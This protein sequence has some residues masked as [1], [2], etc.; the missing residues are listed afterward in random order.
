MRPYDQAEEA[1]GVHEKTC[2]RCE[3]SELTENGA[4]RRCHRYPQ[5]MQVEDHH[6]CGEFVGTDTKV[7]YGLVFEGDGPMNPR[8]MTKKE[9]DRARREYD[10]LM[11]GKDH[12]NV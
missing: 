6:W 8:P 12:D 11:F 4:N 3:F 5:A 2:R 7:H 9:H 10:Q 1:E